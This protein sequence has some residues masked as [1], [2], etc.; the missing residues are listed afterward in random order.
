MDKHPSFSPPSFESAPW[1]INGHF[2]TILSSLLV[3]PEHA[4]FVRHTIDTPD[5]DQL[6]LDIVEYSASSPVAILLHG[7][8]GSTK[9]FYIQNLARHLNNSGYTVAALNFRS[10]GG[11]LNAKRRFYHSGETGDLKTVS[12]WLGQKYPQSIQLAAGFSLGGS[13]ILNYLKAYQKSSRIH[14]FAAISVPYDLYKGSIHLQKGFNRIYDYQFVKPLKQKLELKRRQF[15]DL[16]AFEG[17]TLFEFD[18]QVTAPLHGFK[19]AKDYYTRCS[20]A[21]FMDRIQTPGLLIHSREDPLCPF[22]YMPLNVIKENSH[23]QT[24]FPDRGGHVGFWSLPPG[25]VEF[26]VGEYFKCLL[27][28]LM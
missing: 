25:W 5:G 21:F 2:H 26:T 10:C 8:E 24:A 28:S 13:V 9:R 22:D 4:G 1:C 23:L 11:K 16:P 14:G 19:D 15:P 3:K 17:S 12:G 18:D 6:E 20:S 7:L 27:K